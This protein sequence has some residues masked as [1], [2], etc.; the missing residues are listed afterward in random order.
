[1]PIYSPSTAK[2]YASDDATGVALPQPA[3]T[4][5]GDFTL[6]SVLPNPTVDAG[7][8]IYVSQLRSVQKDLPNGSVAWTSR[9]SWTTPS[10][11]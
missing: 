4:P 8:Y 10:L 11:S 3:A 7:G 6:D 2:V 1:M 5:E 9:R